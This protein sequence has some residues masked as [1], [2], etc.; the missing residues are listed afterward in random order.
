MIIGCA[1]PPEIQKAQIKSEPSTANVKIEITNDDKKES[2][3]TAMT[4]M[5]VNESAEEEMSDSETM[6]ES[7]EMSDSKEEMAESEMSELESSEANE[8]EYRT[9]EGSFEFEGYG[10]GKSH[11]GT[12]NT[13]SAE[14]GIQ[15]EEI[16]T[17]N[18][19]I[20]A[21]SVDTGI[22]KL[23]GHLKSDDFF[24]VEN[25]PEIK[26][27]GFSIEDGVAK[28]SLTF[29]GVTNEVSFGIN[30]TDGVSTNFLLD[31]TPFGMKYT[32][33]NKDVRIAFDL[34]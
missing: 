26:F 29:L 4:D 27:E 21:A 13:W 31:T 22:E 5:P 8:I 12:F 24:D 6:S 19:V 23:N 9:A 32:G 11:T 33:I 3:K 18:A 34:K 17:L 25:H 10:P 1:Q 16:V 15:D 30:Q 7:E 14:F 28:G 20:D 2:N